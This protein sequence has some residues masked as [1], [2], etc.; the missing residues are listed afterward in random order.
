MSYGSKDYLYGTDIPGLTN[1]TSNPENDKN[2]KNNTQI[3]IDYCNSQGWNLSDAAPAFSYCINFSPGYKDGEWYL[4][5][6]GELKLFYDNREKFKSDLSTAGITTN[7]DSDNVEHSVLWSSTEYSDI[8]SYI[9]N[10]NLS[11]PLHHFAKYKIRYILP[12]L[13]INYVKK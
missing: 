12:F 9:L 8:D 10:P 2:G 11:N 13:A 7:M 5:S 6:M 3:V 4:P 1:Y